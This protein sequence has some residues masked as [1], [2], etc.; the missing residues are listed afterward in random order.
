LILYWKSGGLNLYTVDHGRPQSIVDRSNGAA[1]GS[2]ELTLRAALVSGSTPR[3]GEKGDELRGVL[4]DNFNGWS[5]GG[6]EPVASFN[7]GG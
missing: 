6:I 7:G 4:T 1:T 2:L 5:R 3:V